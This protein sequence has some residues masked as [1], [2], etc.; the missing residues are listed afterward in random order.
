MIKKMKK[1]VKSAYISFLTEILKGSDDRW[2]I[3]GSHIDIKLKDIVNIQ[4]ITIYSH[5][6]YYSVHFS[7]KYENNNSFKFDDYNLKIKKFRNYRIYNR[8]NFIFNLLNNKIE[9]I[10]QQKILSCIPKNIIRKEKFKKI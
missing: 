1:N 6:L 3:I 5:F 9:Y 10:H 8:I 2:T 4:D 7:V